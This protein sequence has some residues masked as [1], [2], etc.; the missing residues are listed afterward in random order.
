MLLTWGL[1]LD[2]KINLCF[3]YNHMFNQL[4]QR[5]PRSFRFISIIA[6]LILGLL[7]AIIIALNIYLLTDN[8]LFPDIVYNIDDVVCIAPA[9]RLGNEP[10]PGTR[11][12]TLLIIAVAYVVCFI[13]EAVFDEWE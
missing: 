13:L 2:R 3:T 4:F 5:Y 11:D 12:Y 9:P 10:K 6:S 1:F 7:L 8:V